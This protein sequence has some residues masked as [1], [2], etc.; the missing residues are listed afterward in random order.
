[1]AA[2]RVLDQAGARSWELSPGDSDG[3]QGLRCL[4][5]HL[6]PPPPPTGM[7]AESW[8]WEWGWDLN[9][10]TQM[11]DVNISNSGL[12]ARQIACLRMLFFD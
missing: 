1:M 11:K 8:T 2:V 4:S 7:L 12:I 5:C 9:P 10:N 6:L 3:W